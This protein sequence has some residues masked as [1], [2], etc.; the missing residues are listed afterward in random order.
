MERKN[1]SDQ[2]FVS[3]DPRPLQSVLRT[4]LSERLGYSVDEADP[5]YLI[6]CSILPTLTQTL[7]GVD[8]GFKAQ[9]LQF[10]TGVNLDAIGISEG[11]ERR[12]ET[13]RSQ[14]TIML[15][16]KN[17]GWFSSDITYSCRVQGKVP[18]FTD[19]SGAGF[20]DY[21][22]TDQI[23]E[24]EGTIQRE[25]LDTSLNVQ[26]IPVTLD[27][28]FDGEGYLTPE[29]EITQV[30]D[31]SKVHSNAAA[32]FVPTGV[33][34]SRKGLLAEDDDAFATRIY[35]ARLARSA[36]G[37]KHWYL[38]LIRGQFPEVTDIATEVDTSDI[39]MYVLTDDETRSENAD[40]VRHEVQRFLADRA[41]I[42]DNIYIRRPLPVG[43]VYD[44]DAKASLT[45][46]FAFSSS[47]A[48]STSTEIESNVAAMLAAFMSE[49]SKKF[50]WTLDIAEFIA[51]VKRA[52]D[53]LIAVDTSMSSGTHSTPNDH[54]FWTIDM[55]NLQFNWI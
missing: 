35:D 29:L 2:I 19:S 30:C 53:S 46:I 54:A 22:L 28:L 21:T 47:E 1:L 32:E 5:C 37:S 41:F 10:S 55:I 23:W 45:I 44:G 3:S 7:A 4:K 13:R 20:E 48:G 16:V 49:E 43:Q 38:E 15:E 17:A 6:G 24:G 42:G 36:Y 31:F 12:T 26:Y 27:A 39:L 33:Y 52:H 25:S 9:L 11:L 34:I 8:A 18:F 51:R 50:Q 40:A 14:L